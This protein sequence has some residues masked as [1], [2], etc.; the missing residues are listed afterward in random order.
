MGLKRS[1]ADFVVKSTRVRSVVQ[2]MYYLSL[3]YDT[4]LPT[5]NLEYV[6]RQLTGSGRNFLHYQIA[7]NIARELQVVGNSRKLIRFG[8]SNDGGYVMSIP[9][10]RNLTVL[11]LGIGNDVSWEKSVS[12]YARAIH[13]Y[14]H[15]VE[16]IPERID[17][18]IHFREKIGSSKQLGTTTLASCID[19]LPES[20][21]YILK[22]DIEGWEWE[23][24]ADVDVNLLEKFSQIVIEFHD[25][26][27]YFAEL[28]V[29]V[30]LNVLRK[31]NVNHVVVNIHPNNFGK[32]AIIGNHPVPDILEVTYQRKSLPPESFINDYSLV[33]SPNTM[34]Q[35]EIVLR[36]P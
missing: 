10:T 6:E 9:Q 34:S 31:L 21:D 35:P 36:F 1:V 29:D 25:F 5:N 33:N 18:A 13:L 7:R 2:R 16:Q 26:H 24:L 11:S 20:D 3:R 17:G 4:D 19:R 15:S 32:F 12:E 28:D 22:M 8:G 27:K 30:I 23:A 14:D